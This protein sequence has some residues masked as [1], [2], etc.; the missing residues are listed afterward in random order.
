MKIICLDENNP[1]T[2]QVYNWLD[3]ILRFGCDY[4]P[5]I[6][7]N[8]IESNG[9]ILPLPK[10]ITKRYYDEIDEGTQKLMQELNEKLKEN[11]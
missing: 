11:V 7:L 4:L 2:L 6:F 5:F 1:Y 9:E 8:K 3:A 10:W